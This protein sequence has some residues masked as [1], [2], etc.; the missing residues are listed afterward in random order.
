[1][2]RFLKTLQQV[3]NVPDDIAKRYITNLS[4]STGIQQLIDMVNRYPGSDSVSLDYILTYS[5]TWS[6]TPEGRKFWGDICCALYNHTIQLPIKS[7]AES[8]KK[9][10]KR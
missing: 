2:H 7:P 4:E 1:M 8:L 10:I 3:P 6:N 5:F 9:P